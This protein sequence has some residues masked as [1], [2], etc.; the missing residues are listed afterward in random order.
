MPRRAGLTNGMKRVP[1]S[2]IS[3]APTG[4][5]LIPAPPPLPP[6]FYSASS[7]ARSATR[8]KT[9]A[10][11]GYRNYSPSANINWVAIDVS[12]ARADL[13]VIGLVKKKIFDQRRG[14]RNRFQPE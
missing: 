5:A 6:R 11:T 8:P 12:H 2:V 10:H 14:R 3:S 9:I 4:R 13:E 7:P 1:V